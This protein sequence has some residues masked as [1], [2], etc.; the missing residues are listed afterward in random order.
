M[1]GHG[2]IN[3]AAKRNR[4]RAHFSLPAGAGASAAADGGSGGYRYLWRVSGALLTSYANAGPY[5][6]LQS[7]T[8]GQA[9]VSCTVTDSA[10]NSISGSAVIPAHGGANP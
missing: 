1:H 4:H 7:Y 2:R 3:A 10:G 8:G 6:S 5:V 9:T